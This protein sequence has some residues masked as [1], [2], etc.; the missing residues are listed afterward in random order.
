MNWD[1]CE[2]LNSDKEKAPTEIFYNDALIPDIPAPPTPDAKWGYGIP[3][4]SQALKWFKLLLLDNEDMDE[5]VCDSAQIRKARELLEASGKTAVQVISDYLYFLWSHTIKNIQ[6][7]MGDS[8]VDG[9]P[10]RVVI[11]VPAVWNHKA[12]A[13]MKRAALKSGILDQRLCGETILHFVSEPEAAALATFDDMKS[14]PDFNVGD[15]IVVCDA[16]GGTVDLISYKVYKEQPLELRECVEG[17]G[18]LFQTHSQTPLTQSQVVFV[19]Q[20]S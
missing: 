17:Q 13:R 6:Q 7:D 9:T 3:T 1:A 20:S 10:F 4:S 15:S 19:E 2:Y 16:G 12:I 14:R 11:T 5:T 18:K 8:A